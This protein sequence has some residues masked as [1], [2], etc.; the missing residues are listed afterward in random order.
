MGPSL[1]PVDVHLDFFPALVAVIFMNTQRFIWAATTVLF[2]VAGAL[3]GWS[4][5]QVYTRFDAPLV[6]I[7]SGAPTRDAP[8][9]QGAQA[10]VVILTL[11][12][13]V[14]IVMARFGSLVADRFLIP[15]LSRLHRVSAADRVLGVVGAMLGLV[16]GVL[17]T[18][19]IP[20]LPAW[21]PIKFCVM[22][23]TAALGMAFFQGMRAEML[24]VF[25]QLEEDASSATGGG[26]IPKFLDTNIIIDGRLADICKTGFI[27]GPICVPQFV[28]EEVQHIADS[29][30]SMRR[31]RGRRGLDV[32][33]AMRELT[34]P[35]TV[36]GQTV[37]VPVVHVLNDIPSS[38][39]KISAVDSK[40]VALARERNGA[41]ITNDFNLNKVAELQGVQVLNLNELAQALKPV[42]LPGEEMQITIVKE[43]KEP[44]QGVGYL[45]DG[46]MVVVADGVEHIGET[47]RVIISSVYQ[48]VAGKMIFADMKDKESRV[49]VKGAGDDLFE[50][51]SGNGRKGV[52]GHSV[53]S[54]DF[55]HRPG[56]G[57]RRKSRS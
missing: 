26:A 13:G 37:L 51:G 22:A 32:L 35:Q 43:G 21:L 47:C 4:L 6:G 29:S 40:L 45:E 15:S 34:V 48:T 7:G 28:L 20:N 33:N 57:V 25:P 23:V 52:Q 36:G 19:P 24:R 46:T 18:L 12:L 42:V 14:A 27:E 30:D 50:A 49:Q 3:L 16:F 44:S 9:V 55:G 39:Q 53:N 31:A 54:D 56:G 1:I 10:Q 11:T 5:G 2:C 38:I 17:I 41:I 8:L